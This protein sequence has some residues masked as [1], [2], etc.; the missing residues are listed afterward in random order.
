MRWGNGW[1]TDK[2]AAEAKQ[3]ASRA[4]QLALDTWHDWFAWYPVRTESCWIWRET[5]SRRR[6][7]NGFKEPTWH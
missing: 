5:V 7:R 3:A 6:T 4:K 1:R 2:A